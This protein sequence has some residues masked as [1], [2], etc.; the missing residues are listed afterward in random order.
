MFTEKNSDY[1]LGK[2]FYLLPSNVLIYSAEKPKGQIQPS[3]KAPIVG[4]SLRC[5]PRALFICGEITE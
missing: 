3:D 4:A 1:I 5:A 2:L